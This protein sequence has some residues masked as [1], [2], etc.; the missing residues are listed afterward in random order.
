MGERIRAYGWTDTALGDPNSWCQG[1]RTAVRVLLTTQHPIFVFWGEDHI[2]LYNDAFARSLGPEKHPSIL[3]APGRQS[4]DEIWPIIGPQIEQVMRGDGA[5][6]HENQMVPILRHGALQEVY[7]TYSYSPIDEPDSAHGVGGVLV[8]CTETTE[9]VLG[10][11]ALAADRE[12]FVRLFDQAPTFLAVLEG[13]EHVVQLANPGYMELIGHRSVV[14]R[15]V[16][17][18]LPDAVAQGYVDILDDVYRSGKSYSAV[19]A[20]YDMQAEPD[21]PIED[22][23]RNDSR[24]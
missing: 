18:A 7:W 15:S 2:C 8:I 11:R 16:A 22:S 23:F 14:G 5:T 6:W 1:L 12:R 19:G 21:G 10:K 20:R 9:H 24:R 13:P 4:W 17:D 3:G